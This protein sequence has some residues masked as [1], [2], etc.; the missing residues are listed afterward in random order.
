[1]LYFQTALLENSSVPLAPFIHLFPL[2]NGDFPT[3]ECG[4]MSPLGEVS[5][6]SFLRP[7]ENSYKTLESPRYVPPHRL[8]ACSDAGESVD[9]IFKH[10]KPIYFCLAGTERYQS[11]Q[12]LKKLLASTY[13][14]QLPWH[15]ERNFCLHVKPHMRRISR[16]RR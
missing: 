9:N 12:N 7:S 4:F 11:F 5:F 10:L 13:F 3:F 2:F 16:N 14:I 15:G 6:I 8:L 1:M